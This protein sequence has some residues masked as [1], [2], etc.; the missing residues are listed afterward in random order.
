[1]EK[2]LDFIVLKKENIKEIVFEEIKKFEESDIYKQIE[3]SNK[4]YIKLGY[5]VGYE[6]TYLLFLEDIK[7][8]KRK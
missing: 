1:V 2:C 4:N 6:I 3:D 5:E 8:L 7:G